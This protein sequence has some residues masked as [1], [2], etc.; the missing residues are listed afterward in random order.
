M[1]RLLLTLLLTGCAMPRPTE[2][3]HA[4]YGCETSHEFELQDYQC[5]VEARQ[6][7][8]TVANPFTGG[9]MEGQSRGECLRVHGWQRTQL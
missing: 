8:G 2:W 6:A 4:Q 5:K 3:C 1:T 7:Y 9:I